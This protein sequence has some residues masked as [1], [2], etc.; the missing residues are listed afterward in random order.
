MPIQ[1]SSQVMLEQSKAYWVS[2]SLIALNVDAIDGSCYLY[3]SRSASLSA[4][5]NGIEGHDL[6]IKLEACSDGLPEYFNCSPVG[7]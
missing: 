7:D 3:S 1:L 5:D 2:K 6:K 4:V